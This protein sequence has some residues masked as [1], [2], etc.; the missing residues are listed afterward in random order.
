MRRLA[1]L[2]LLP[3][4]ERRLSFSDSVDAVEILPIDDANESRAYKVMILPIYITRT[5]TLRS[6]STLKGSVLVAYYCFY[7]TTRS[8]K[9]IILARNL[10][11]TNIDSRS[12]TYRKLGVNI[13]VGDNH[14][15]KCTPN[16]LLVTTGNNW[17]FQEQIPLITSD[18]FKGFLTPLYHFERPKQM[19][20]L[21]LFRW[22][23]GGW[24]GGRRI[25]KRLPTSFPPAPSKNVTISPKSS[26]L[27]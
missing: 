23:R 8:A 14:S 10:V 2:A 4:L 18:V 21:A 5:F 27:F 3:F 6:I 25:I 24:G 1:L 20:K 7:S 12:K 26:T 17:K 16:P 19:F 11:S 9:L 22:G 15:T 13:C